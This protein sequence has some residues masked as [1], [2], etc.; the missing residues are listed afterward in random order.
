[1]K[2]FNIILFLLLFPILSFSE[3]GTFF[4][5]TIS[6]YHREECIRKG[7]K[8]IELNVKG[9][10]RE[11]YFKAPS[12]YW[13]LGSII[14]FHKEDGDASNFCSNIRASLPMVEF[15]NEAINM[16]FSVFSLESLENSFL[17]ENESFCGKMFDAFSVNNSLNNDLS[18]TKEVI[19]KL[20][21][22]LRPVGS[23]KNVF[24]VGVSN[25]GFMAVKAASQLFHLISGF[26]VI[27]AGDPYG[28]KI[29][30]F[31]SRSRLSSYDR[32]LTDNETKKN[33][34]KEN[35]CKSAS[36]KNELKWPEIKSRFNLPFILL[37]HEGDPF[38][39]SSCVLKL[40]TILVSNSFEGK[41]DFKVKQ[42]GWKRSVNHEWL[43][44][45]NKPLLDFFKRES[46]PLDGE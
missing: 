46:N 38:I 4:Q 17:A 28:T 32:V 5:N 21:P 20:I 27:S 41:K 1:M 13:S 40:K 36:Y 30:C 16:G 22:E 42:K 33:L 11:L 43:E 24:L 14:I 29:S 6:D 44:E 15:S 12:G 25:G 8:R 39:D 7:W 26:A 34:G 9:K 2:T 23:K 37:Y 31:K 18:F 10:K 19:T 35:S 45:Y 3:N